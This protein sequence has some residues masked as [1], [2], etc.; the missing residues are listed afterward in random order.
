[1]QISLLFA[2]SCNVLQHI[3]AAAVCQMVPVFNT[4]LF[5]HPNAESSLVVYEQLAV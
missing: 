2:A 5:T 1:M 4:N 3:P